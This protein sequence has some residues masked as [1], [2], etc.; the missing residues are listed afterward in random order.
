MK[1][2]GYVRVSSED[3]NPERQLDQIE[4]DKIF[5]DRISGKNM[6]RPAL[7]ELLNYIRE[8]DTLIVHS[9]DRL[10]RSL[11]DLRFI[12]KDLTS[13]KIKIQF[14][15]ENLIFNDDNSPMAN[16]ML[17]IMGAFAEFERAI[18]RERQLEG[19]AIAKKRGVYKGRK[20][21]LT[22]D[23]ID[24]L[25]TRAQRGENKSQIARDFNISRQTVYEYI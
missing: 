20:K 11:D 10:A 16:L 7:K 8:Q 19:I 23:Q 6:D 2:I 17:S 1:R 21:S 12:V 15:K 25:K 4:L 18:I 9:M 3:Q 14:I 22:N 5:V 13:K 24:T